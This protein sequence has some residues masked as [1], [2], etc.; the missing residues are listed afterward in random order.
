M[1]NKN[2][3]LRFAGAIISIVLVVGGLIYQQEKI[4][5]EGSMTILETRPVDPRDLFRGEYVI[6]RYAIEN[7]EKIQE[8]VAKLKAGDTLFIKLVEDENGVA[9][10]SGV[11][12]RSPDSFEGLWIAGEINGGRVRF[13]SLEQFYVPEGA[14]RSIE[15][16]RSDLHVEVV[17]NKG[18]ARVVGLLDGSLNKIDPE[19]FLE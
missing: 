6:L 9:S 3:H 4:L 10:V 5:Q 11:S 18:E 15:D 14:G 13:P 8:E 12:D 17:L 1:I 2:K 7:D 16:F 19:S